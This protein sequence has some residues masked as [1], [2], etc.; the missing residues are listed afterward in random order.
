MRDI[1]LVPTEIWQDIIVRACTDGGRT[2]KSLALTS[3]HFHSQSYDFRFYSIALSSLKQLE[4]FLA[5]IRALPVAPRLSVHHLWLSFVDDD[6]PKLDAW[7]ANPNPTEHKMRASCNAQTRVPRW[8]ARFLA[9]INELLPLVAPT[10]ETLSILQAYRLPLP[11]FDLDLPRLRELTI[12]NDIA[13][14]TSAHPGSISSILRLPSLERLHLVTHSAST[15]SIFLTASPLRKS[16]I[17][18][19]RFSAVEKWDMKTAFPRMLAKALG[20]PAPQLSSE[21]KATPDSEQPAMVVRAGAALPH[22]RELV[23]HG[24]G[25]QPGACPYGEEPWDAVYDLLQGLVETCGRVKEER[26]R[27]HVM[28]RKWRMDSRW[29]SRLWN[30]WLSRIEGGQGC[31]VQSDDEEAALEEAVGECA[32]EIPM[33]LM[34]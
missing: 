34:Y 9:A 31:W 12:Y 30:D 2:G 7:E 22:V 33:W 10:L 11:R 29:R 25:P 24:V 17:T 18:H 8:Q 3:K 20:L 16:P 6:G 4:G 13:I 19:L 15:R 5:F 21:R 32:T 28:E 1:T 14:F 27:A 23:V 26:I